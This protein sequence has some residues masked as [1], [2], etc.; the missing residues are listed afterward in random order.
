MTILNRALDKAYKRQRVVAP[1][2]APTS[3]PATANGWASQLR[4]PVRSLPAMPP[5]ARTP[6]ATVSGMVEKPSLPATAHPRAVSSPASIPLAAPAPAVALSG[7]KVRID[8]RHLPAAAT[9]IV[10]IAP[11]ETP[12]AAKAEPAAMPIAGGWIWPAIV[13]KLLAS[14]ARADIG[15]LALNLKNLATDRGL[16]CVALTGPGRGTGR[17]TLV[18]TLARLLSELPSTRVAI[19]DADFGHPEAARLLE[20]Q[21]G[22]GLWDAA[23]GE[24]KSPAA[25]QQLVPGKLALVPLTKPVAAATIDRGKIRNLHS[26]LRSLRRDNAI[27]LVDA[28]PWESLVPPLIFESHAVDASICVCRADTASDERLDEEAMRQPGVECLGTIE[29]FTQS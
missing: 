7:A 1:T 8:A 10:G 2:A 24:G 25:V 27:V 6:S 21:P 23:C 16:G 11:V 12:S 26:F 15:K 28:G 3:A 9:A 4:E 13:D 29:T 19:V 20:L 17:T 14:R 18:L 5:H 22:A